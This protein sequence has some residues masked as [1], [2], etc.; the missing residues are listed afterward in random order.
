MVGLSVYKCIVY[1]LATFIKCSVVI[2]K[3]ASME[4]LSN[5]DISVFT[6]SFVIT[7]LHRYIRL[8]YISDKLPRWMMDDPEIKPFYTPCKGHSTSSSCGA[9]DEI[10]GVFPMIA[11]CDMC[12]KNGKILFV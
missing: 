2:V 1:V 4:A 6:K 9:F 10:D 5:N 8:W 12:T 3:I 11:Y 7:K